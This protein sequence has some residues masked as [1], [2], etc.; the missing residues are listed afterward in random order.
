MNTDT[1]A[2][3]TKP[4]EKPVREKD[5]MDNRQNIKGKTKSILRDGKL[6]EQLRRGK[7]V[8]I[9]KLQSTGTQ[10]DDVFSSNEGLSE[11][12]KS[13]PFPSMD[14]PISAGMLLFQTVSTMSIDFQF[15]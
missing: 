5:V 8:S 11:D 9:Q 15:D 4:V 10:T 1:K 7:D 13:R 2:L 12:V 6:R 3:D 14:V